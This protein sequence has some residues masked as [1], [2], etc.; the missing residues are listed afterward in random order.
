MILLDT[1]HLSVFQFADHPRAVALNERLRSSA[2]GPYATTVISFEEQVRGWL[3]EVS[4]ARKADQQ[5]HAYQ[6]L[7]KLAEFFGE[8]HIIRFDARAAEEFARLRKQHRRLGAQDLKI[9][10]IAR[11]NGALLLTANLRDF[12]QVPGLR[13]ENWLV[14]AE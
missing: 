14:S 7:A 12:G 3:A 13:A 2:E 8:W 11:V 4:R 5:V 9:A 6:E 10:A 1:D